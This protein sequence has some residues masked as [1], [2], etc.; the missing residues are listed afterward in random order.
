MRVKLRSKIEGR[1][2]F[3]GLKEILISDESFLKFD[4]VLHMKAENCLIRPNLL[5]IFV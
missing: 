2:M 5:P 1:K 4:E 3:K